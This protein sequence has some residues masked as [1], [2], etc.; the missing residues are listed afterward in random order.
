VI[1]TQEHLSNLV[2]AAYHREMEIY[3]YQLN[4]DNYTVMLVGLPQDG[5]PDA[6]V[7]YKETAIDN[8]PQDFDDAKVGLVADYQYRDRLRNLLRTEKVECGRATKIRDALKEQ[9]G[10]DYDALIAACK[11]SQPA[12]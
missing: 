12:A 6:L 10:A 3:Q 5:W 7:Q 1:T 9:I 4:V 2:V 8:L 11:A